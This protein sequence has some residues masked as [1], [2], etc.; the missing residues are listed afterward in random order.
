LLCAYSFVEVNAISRIFNT[1]HA[2]AEI[3]PD[4]VGLSY[5]SSNIFSD[6]M[7]IQ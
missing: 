6:P 2:E 4:E 5:Y 1:E 7:E 3:L